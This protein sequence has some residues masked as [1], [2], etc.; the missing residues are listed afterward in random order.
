MGLSKN[1]FDVDFIGHLG[2]EKYR[3][4]GTKESIEQW[5]SSER[6]NYGYLS[7]TV[8]EAE[9]ATAEFTTNRKIKAIE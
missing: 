2:K 6:A 8:D 9:P 7:T 3:V 1:W 4:F 5:A